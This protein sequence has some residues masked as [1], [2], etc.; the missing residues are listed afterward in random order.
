MKQLVNKSPI[1]VGQVC[2]VIV[3]YN[4][5]EYLKKLGFGNELIIQENLEGIESN[6]ICVTNEEIKIYMPFSELINIE[7]EKKRLLNEKARLEKEVER[8]K[9]ILENK[10]FIAKAPKEKVDEE[11]EKL[12]KY[13]KLLE[14]TENSLKRI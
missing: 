1:T 11:K 7:E 5:K 8:S 14:E 3:T 9:K 4:R 6:A 2:A 13:I 12:E 10:G